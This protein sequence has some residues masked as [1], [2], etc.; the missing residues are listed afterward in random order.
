MKKLLDL[1]TFAQN[2]R[3]AVVTLGVVLLVAASLVATGI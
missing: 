3:D 2:H 1:A